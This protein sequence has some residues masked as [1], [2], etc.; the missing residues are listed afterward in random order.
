MGRTYR[1]KAALTVKEVHQAIADWLA[2]HR[3]EKLPPVF[4]SR[5]TH[6][7]GQGTYLYEWTDDAEGKDKELD[8][9]VGVK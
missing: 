1:N 8:E 4:W 2:Q 3:G 6:S 9:I 7:Q 5:L